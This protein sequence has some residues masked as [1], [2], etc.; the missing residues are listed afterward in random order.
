MPEMEPFNIESE[1]ASV[2]DGFDDEELY[3]GP[4]FYFAKANRWPIS[5]Y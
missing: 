5:S 1:M 3:A 4:L 2:L